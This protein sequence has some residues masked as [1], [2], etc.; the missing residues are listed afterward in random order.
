MKDALSETLGMII[1]DSGNQK[2]KLDLGQKQEI[3]KCDIM[4][5]FQAPKELCDPQG[6]SMVQT[7]ENSQWSSISFRCNTILNESEL[8]QAS[9]SMQI[10]SRLTLVGKPSFMEVLSVSPQ[11]KLKVEIQHCNK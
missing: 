4:H 1:N 7:E 6:D 9:V 11:L 8:K 10:S 3:L 2:M 5:N